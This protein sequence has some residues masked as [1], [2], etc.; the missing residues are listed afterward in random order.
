MGFWYSSKLSS[1]EFEYELE[2]DEF[3]VIEFESDCKSNYYKILLMGD[4]ALISNDVIIS[5]IYLERGENTF[6]A[7]SV[8]SL[9]IL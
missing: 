8:V 4:F 1:R 7:I 9:I 3:A 5:V 6:V 2:L